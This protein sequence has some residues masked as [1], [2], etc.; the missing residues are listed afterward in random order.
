MASVPIGLLSM[1]CE[2][3]L[4]DMPVCELVALVP[5]ASVMVAMFPGAILILPSVV[6]MTLEMMPI[7][8]GNILILISVASVAVDLV[9]NLRRHVL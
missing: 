2:D 7:F 4:G 6:S 1:L 9:A 3:L 8:C 5:V